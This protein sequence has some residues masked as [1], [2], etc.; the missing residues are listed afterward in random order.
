M[1]KH[2]SGFMEL[3]IS[4]FFETTCPKPP[5]DHYQPC[6]THRLGAENI[7]HR[8]RDPEKMGEDS[9]GTKNQWGKKKLLSFLRNVR[10]PLVLDGMTLTLCSSPMCTQ[11]PG[12]M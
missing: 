12:S 7:K 4:Y 3:L 11:E 6:Q 9:V 5:D 2:Y 10:R 8:M 1:N